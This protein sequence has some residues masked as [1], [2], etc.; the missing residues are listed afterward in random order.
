MRA[1]RRS[2][3]SISW[4]SITLGSTSRPATGIPTSASAPNRTARLRASC[5]P[6]GTSA[7]SRPKLKTAIASSPEQ[8]IIT[9]FGPRRRTS[10]LDQRKADT[11]TGEERQPEPG[12]EALA[13]P[14]HDRR[15]IGH[16]R[17]DQIDAE[18]EEALRED[19]DAERA[20][21]ER[22]HDGAAEREVRGRAAGVAALVDRR[23]RRRAQHQREHRG[24]HHEDA[25]RRLRRQAERRVRDRARP[26]RPSRRRPRSETT[27]ARAACRAR[28]APAGSRRSPGSAPDRARRRR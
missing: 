4:P 8:S 28:R 10:A 2:S 26:A 19:V 13:P 9:R 18:D 24:A 20:V 5:G 7:R 6:P 15:E 17:L 23:D 3:R 25:Q 16:D 27:P 22:L 21:A 11:D 12:G 1:A 14:E